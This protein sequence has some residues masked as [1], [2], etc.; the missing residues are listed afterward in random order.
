MRVL[1]K[2]REV[3][4]SV[5][6]SSGSS[7]MISC[8]RVMVG[9]KKSSSFPNN[10]QTGCV[11]GVGAAICRKTDCHCE[12]AAHN[13][14]LWGRWRVAPDEAAAQAASPEG[15]SNEGV[16]GTAACGRFVNRPYDIYRTWRRGDHWSPAR[17]KPHRPEGDPMRA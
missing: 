15:R 4:S 1:T 3:V 14:P 13:L 2:D 9:C 6:A 12:E 17:R 8:R 11:L 10:T 7:M 5:C 16:M